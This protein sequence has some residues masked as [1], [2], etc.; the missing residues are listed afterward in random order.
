MKLTLK[1]VLPV[2]AAATLF[3]AQAQTIVD[4][5]SAPGGAWNPANQPNFEA[6]SPGGGTLYTDQAIAGETN[7][8]ID[9]TGAIWTSVVP[10][11]PPYPG[12]GIYGDYY[13]TLFS[14]PTITLSTSNILDNV[15]TIT[16]SLAA[17]GAG[18]NSDTVQLN[19]GGLQSATG[20]IPVDLGPDPDFPTNR[21]IYT[22]TWDVSSLAVPS[23]F[24]LVWTTPAEHTP[25]FSAEIVQAV[26]EPSAMVMA[27]VGISFVLTRSRR[28]S[29]R[30]KSS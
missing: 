4:S 22:W 12:I 6:A 5:W 3:S 19:F 25:Y 21:Y 7:N 16:F 8:S 23:T 15:Q 27:V 11:S 26:P 10:P 29:C 18:F 28:R 9:N 2:A 14:T 13:Y 30:S 20:F 24:S 1:K 17:A